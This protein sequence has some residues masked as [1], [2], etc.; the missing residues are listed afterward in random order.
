MKQAT[1]HYDIHDDDDF[2]DDDDDDDVIK[3]NSDCDANAN[4]YNDY[5]N[6]VVCIN[7]CAFIL[8]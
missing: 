3:M 8:Y 6:D 7:A 4:S 5:N 2:N 1:P